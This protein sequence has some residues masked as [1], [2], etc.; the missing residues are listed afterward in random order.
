MWAAD[1]IMEE[2]EKLHPD[3]YPQ[4]MAQGRNELGHTLTPVN[5]QPLPKS[6]LLKMYGKCGDVL[7]RGTVKTLIKRGTVQIHFPEITAQA[8]KIHD[9][10]A[11][12]LVVLQG[13]ES[14]FVCVLRNKDDNMNAQ[15]SIIERPESPP[16]S[17]EPLPVSG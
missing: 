4:T 1:K 6:D 9:L 10:L 5:P 14:V 2:L 15:V 3:F 17:F 12:H 8:Q 16:P 7:H 11:V 13:A